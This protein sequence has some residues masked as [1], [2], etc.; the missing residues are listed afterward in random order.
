MATTDF[1]ACTVA[2]RRF[3]AQARVLADSFFE[4]H[5]SGRFAVLIPDDPDGERTLD[6]RAEVL[7][8]HDIGVD[9]AEAERMA[10]AYSVRELSC[11]MKV[12]LVHHLLEQGERAVMLDG[13]VCVYGDLTPVAELASRE[14]LVLLPHALTPHA[15]PDRYPPTV[16]LAP[17]MRNAVGPEQ[18]MILSGTYNTGLAAFAPAAMPFLE[19][20]SARTKR[21]CLYE[22]ARGLFQEQGWTALAPALFPCH[23]LREHGWNVSGFHLHDRDVEWDGGRPRIGGKP[24][25]CF[26]FITYDP[27]RPDELSANEQLAGVWPAAADRPGAMRL[28]R[29]YA[30]RLLAAGHEEALADASPYDRLPDGTPVDLFMR[31]AYG[32]ALLEYEAGRAPEPPNPYSDG[33]SERFL[34]WLAAP[35]EDPAGGAPVSR[36]LVAVHNRLPWVWGTFREVPG[37]DAEGYVSWLPVAADRGDLDLP[38]R[39]LPERQPAPVDPAFAEL[40][41][42]SERLDAHRRALEDVVQSIRHSRSWRMT[43]PVRSLGTIVRR[44]RRDAAAPGGGAKRAL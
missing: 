14:G 13:D 16:G 29:E 8:P 4:H 34:V 40:L 19:W 31:T 23:V 17:R 28:C 2:S 6:G 38:D 1:V 32:E 21:Y 12:R 36:Y 35:A 44:I 42:H 41:E 18:M 43:A 25:R 27:T 5:P 22:S 20:W 3:L 37:E 39:W 10:L 7:R 11:A 24:L 9:P 30:D 15:T 33:D 26:H